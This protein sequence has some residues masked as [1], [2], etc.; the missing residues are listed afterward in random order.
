ML[1]KLQLKSGKMQKKRCM[2]WLYMY[3]SQCLLY[4][5]VCPKEPSFSAT[6]TDGVVPLFPEYKKAAIFYSAC[7]QLEDQYASVNRTAC[8]A[9]SLCLHQDTICSPQLVSHNSTLDVEPHSV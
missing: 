3:A 5:H 6:Q 2:R 4:M 9:Q 8:V 1:P 7:D